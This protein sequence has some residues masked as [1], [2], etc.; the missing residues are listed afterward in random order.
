MVHKVRAVQQEVQRTQ[1]CNKKLQASMQI[2]NDIMQLV[3]ELREKAKGGAY[4]E[5]EMATI[6]TLMRNNSDIIEFGAEAFRDALK[7][8]V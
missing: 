1:A 5:K 7:D 3:E 8:V 4:S 2:I 6:F